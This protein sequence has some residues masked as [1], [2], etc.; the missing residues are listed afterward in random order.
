MAAFLCNSALFLL[1]APLQMRWTSGLLAAP[2]SYLH[3]RAAQTGS[4][5]A[6]T[7]VLFELLQSV[8]H[9]LDHSVFLGL[10]HPFSGQ[11]TEFSKAALQP[12]KASLKSLSEGKMGEEA[13]IAFL[14]LDIP[15]KKAPPHHPLYDTPLAGSEKCC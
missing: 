12:S 1:W 9:C 10:E 15:A 14:F 4:G 2:T 8:Q 3:R 7:S 11:G 13:Q 6:L 5:H